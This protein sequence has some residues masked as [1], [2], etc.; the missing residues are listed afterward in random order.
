MLTVV[1]AVPI[2]GTFAIGHGSIVLIYGYV[3]L[4]DF[5]R[6]LG[7]SNVE[8]IPHQIFDVAPFLKYLLYTPT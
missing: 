2:I 7:H 8:I 5:L 1:V 6:C 3:L 4:F